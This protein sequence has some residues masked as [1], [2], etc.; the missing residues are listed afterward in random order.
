MH[1]INLA[2]SNLNYTYITAFYLI[3]FRLWFL[4]LLLFYKCDRS[5]DYLGWGGMS[6]LSLR[7]HRHL[8][9]FLSFHLLLRQLNPPPAYGGRCFYP[10]TLALDWPACLPHGGGGK[11]GKTVSEMLRASLTVNHSPFTKYS[12]VCVR[13]Q[14]PAIFK[15]LN[16]IPV[17]QKVYV[18]CMIVRKNIKK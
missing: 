12:A 2:S 15:G 1:K 3:I 5:R 9:L 11:G 18:L 6:A 8:Q 14:P 10:G 17:N 16:F 7:I 4:E 13:S